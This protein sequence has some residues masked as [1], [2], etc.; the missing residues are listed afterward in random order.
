V[1]SIC[2]DFNSAYPHIKRDAQPGRLSPLVWNRSTTAAAAG[3]V[4]TIRV[5]FLIF[6]FGFIMAS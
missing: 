2:A 3:S 5:V 6:D 1:R 4:T